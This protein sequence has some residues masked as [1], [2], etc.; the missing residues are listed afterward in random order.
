M[1]SPSYLD[2]MFGKASPKP[3]SPED[4]PQYKSLV[5]PVSAA[6]TDIVYVEYD[7]AAEDGMG[8]WSAVEDK[9]GKF[10][11]PYYGRGNSVVRLDAG[12]R[13]TNAVSAGLL[14]AC[15]GRHPFGH[16]GSGRDGMVHRGRGGPHRPA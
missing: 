13:R 1:T 6:A 7:F 8:P 15:R 9:D 14:R 11:I 10:W 3:G 4:L 2:T 5:R 12:D 16:S